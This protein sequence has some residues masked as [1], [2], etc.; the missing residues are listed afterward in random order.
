MSWSVSAKG[1]PDEVVAAIGKY[2]EHFT[3]PSQSK[4]EFEAAKPHLIAL[5][6]QTYIT[7]EGEGAGYPKPVIQFTAYGSGATRDGKEL[8]RDCSVDIKRTY[9]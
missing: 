2:G 8:S 9:S 4:D 6:R 5:V 1:S 7:P 3:V